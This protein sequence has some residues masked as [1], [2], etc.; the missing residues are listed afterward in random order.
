MKKLWIFLFFI[1]SVNANWLEGLNFRQRTFATV[2]IGIADAATRND[3]RG[4]GIQKKTDKAQCLDLFNAAKIKWSEKEKIRPITYTSQMSSW[5]ID[6]DPKSLNSKKRDTAIWGL[7]ENTFLRA[8]SW[9]PTYAPHMK[10]GCSKFYQITD[11]FLIETENE[12]CRIATIEFSGDK[13]KSY[14]MRY[15]DGERSAQLDPEKKDINSVGSDC[16][17]E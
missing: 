14:N 11:S 16:N 7:S 12:K 1:Q 2:A 6:E 8:N 9:N 5:S 3:H 15:C 13:T 10:S 4:G 17:C